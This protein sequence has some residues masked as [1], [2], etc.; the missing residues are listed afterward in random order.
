MIIKIKVPILPLAV[1]TA[2][3]PLQFSG[4]DVSNLISGI[5]PMALVPP[6]EDS[7]KTKT[8][9]LAILEALQ[10]VEFAAGNMSVLDS[11]A[12]SKT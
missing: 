3:K 11:V 10:S 9:Q 7:A 6:G 4:I 5:G 8:A 2:I 12:L 1:D